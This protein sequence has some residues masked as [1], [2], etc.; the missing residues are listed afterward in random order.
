MESGGVS[1]S[2]SSLLNVIDTRRFDV[3]VFIVNPTGVFMELLPKDI[4][5]ITDFKTQ[6]VFS[7]FPNNI[8]SLIS[9][10]FF[11]AAFLRLFAAIIMQ[12][13]KGYGALILSKL[14][15]KITAEFDLAV[16]FNGQQQLY[17]LVNAIK[18]KVKVSFFHSDYSK[19]DFYYKTDKK[20]YPKLDKIFTVS[21]TCVAEMK[22][23]FPLLSSKI[24]LFENITSVD[25][26]KR[27]SDNKQVQLEENAILSIGHLCQAK[28]TSQALAVA[29][30]LKKAG[31]NFTWYFVGQNSH[32]ADYESL[33]NQFEL[34]NNVVFVGVTSN[35]YPYLKQAKVLVH[36][37]KFEGK[38]IALDEAKLLCKPILV[39][40]FSTVTDQFRQHYNATITDFKT[41]NITKNLI[42]LLTNE[43]L[44]NLYATNLKKECFGNESEIEKLYQLI[45]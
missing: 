20:Y 27:L 40:Q 33:V 6:L 30:E 36:L 32:D 44:R 29:F 18:S 19:W 42:D 8:I 35:P 34:Q 45:E 23:Y 28:G 10:R 13:N 41:E 14:I 26:I 4:N 1:K 5:L 9:N 43:T 21:P 38:S 15:H 11:S 12:F 25:F 24:D 17:Y 16:D 2:L 39:T 31:L 3:W 7:K 22:Q 37:S